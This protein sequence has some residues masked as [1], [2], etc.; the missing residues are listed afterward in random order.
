MG[1]I[2]IQKKTKICLRI[3]MLDNEKR[4]KNLRLGLESLI[5]QE[6]IYW[7]RMLRK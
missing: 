6:E 5:T 7:K 2:D 1:N 3:D 4:K